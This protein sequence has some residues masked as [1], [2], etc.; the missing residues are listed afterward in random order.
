MNLQLTGKIQDVEVAAVITDN[1]IPIQA[2]GNTQQLQEFDQVYVQFTKDDHQLIAGDFRIEEQESNFMRYNKK[3]QGLLYSGRFKLNNNV[4]T[5]VSFGAALSR[6]KFGRNVLNGT[7][8]NQGPYRLT[9]SENERFIIILSGTERVYVDGALV[10]RGMDREYVID[11]N[12]GEITFTNNL[13]IT[14]DKRIIVEFQYTD[15]NYARTL[16]AVDNDYEVGEKTKFNLKFY[17]EQDMKYQQLLQTLSEEEVQKLAD[18]GDSLNQAINPKIDSVGYSEELVLYQKIDTIVD[19]SPLTFYRFSVDPDRAFYQLSFSYVGSGNGNY[20]QASSGIN[21]RIFEF[22]PPIGGIPQGDFEPIIQLISPKQQQM[23]SFAWNQEINKNQKVAL[24]TA[25][26]NYN[27]NTFSNKDKADDQG[28]SVRATHE[29]TVPVGKENQKLGLFLAQEYRLISKNFS[30]I[31]RFRSVEFERDWNA[32]ATQIGFNEHYISNT[33]GLQINNKEALRLETAFIDRG[34]NYK[35]NKH[36][37]TISLPLWKAARIEGSGSYLNGV[38]MNTSSTFLRHKA[39]LYQ[40]LKLIEL[41]LWEHEEQKRIRLLGL[42]S[43]QRT[44]SND[45]FRIYGIDVSTSK[46]YRLQTTLGFDRRFDFLPLGPSMKLASTANQ[47]R[48]G[49]VHENEKKTSYLKITSTLR[50]LEVIDTI[51]SSARAEKTLLN[52]L[53]YNFSAFKG[54]INSKTFFEIGTGNELRREYTYVAVTPGQGVFTWNDYN[55]DGVQQLNEFEIAQFTD[56]ATYVRVYLTSNEFVRT[57]TNALTQSLNIT[58]S[59]ISNRSKWHGKLFSR[60]NDQAYIRL[61]QKNSKEDGSLFALPFQQSIN[62]SSLISLTSN[63]RNTIYFNRSNP[64]FGMSYTYS[65]NNN[66]AFLLH[67]FELRALNSHLVNLRFNFLRLYTLQLDGEQ[68]VKTRSSEIF[69][70]GDYLF[71]ALIFSPKLYLQKNAAFRLGLLFDYKDKRN[72]VEYGG[73]RSTFLKAGAEV[74]YSIP[75]KGRWTANFNF[76]QTEFS[77]D[78]TKNTALQ[79]DML[80]GLQ[81]GANYVW[82]VRYQQTFKNNLQAGITYDGRSSPGFKVVHTGGMQVQLLF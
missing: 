36:D 35:G 13:L 6:G 74:T 39:A 64:I 29:T 57:F 54:F 25:V 81:V 16:F 30:P 53:E 61:A 72:A 66:K 34:D 20:F 41:K 22:V 4:T 10:E 17:S 31:E 46:K 19:G 7:E 15:R 58:P 40:D 37:L 69:N 49:I 70:S 38:G 56:Q 43:L 33:I 28:L 2:E 3:A 21:G 63:L 79:F 60:F 75:S 47:Y 65:E 12:A 11:Y 76:V 27:Q 44:V 23:A 77:G 82:G 78:L 80:E 18:V 48:L 52:R 5:G 68:Q 62:D 42:D 73:E 71:N 24:E 32:S 59:K 8:G 1:N 67:G 51:L 55:G 50:E 9:G 14:K 26:S 45:N